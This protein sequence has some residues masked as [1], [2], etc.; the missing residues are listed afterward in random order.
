MACHRQNNTRA[1]TAP[2][3]HAFLH[4]KKFAAL[5][6][7]LCMHTHTHSCIHSFIYIYIY[8]LY[9]YIFIY[10]STYIYI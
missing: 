8:I 4:L 9:I 7:L 10:N 6:V 2:N 1:R 5:H 3:G